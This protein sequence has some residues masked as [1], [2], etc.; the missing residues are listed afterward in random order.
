VVA[1]T[2]AFAGV[3]VSDF[4]EAY[5]WYTR[6]FG[7]PADMFPTDGEAVW[8][9]TSG[10]SVYVV[11]DQDRAG[12]GL[13]TVVVDDLDVYADRLRADGHEL[14]EQ[15]GGTGPRRL[16]VSDDDGNTITFFEDP[17]RPR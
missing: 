4:P 5:E 6:L 16:R 15:S 2:H 3:A 7:R 10:A 12:K 14:T 13:L 11:G 17:A 1:I 9:L 8:H